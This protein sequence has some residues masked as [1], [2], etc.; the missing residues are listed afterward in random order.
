MTRA[1]LRQLRPQGLRMMRVEPQMKL[2]LLLQTKLLPQRL[3]G[4]ASL[5]KGFRCVPRPLPMW[6]REPTT[7]RLHQPLDPPSLIT[8]R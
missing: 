6:F 3:R 8:Q 2:R 5:A 1:K 4:D 7:Q